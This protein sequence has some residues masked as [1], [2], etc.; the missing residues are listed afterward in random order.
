VTRRLFIYFRVERGDETA[1]VAAVREL[2]AAWRVALP[3][4]RCELLRRAGHRGDVTL[5][6]TY[7]CAGGISAEWQ[8]RIE[9]EAQARLEPWL[10]GERHVEV[11]E[12]CA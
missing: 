9:R 5:M 1:V 6:E 8:Q 3:G 7:G 12:P 4:L 10:A 11:F 2:H